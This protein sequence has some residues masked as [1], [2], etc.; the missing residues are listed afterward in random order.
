MG[1]T[2]SLLA[3][4]SSINLRMAGPRRGRERQGLESF[5]AVFER[6]NI[7]NHRTQILGTALDRRASFRCQQLAKR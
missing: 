1:F 7:V 3:N 4:G 6:D 2:S 5:D